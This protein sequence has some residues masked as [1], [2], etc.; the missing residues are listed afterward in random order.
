MRLIIRLFVGLDFISLVLMGMQ[1]WNIIHHFDQIVKQPEMVT[2][3]LKF[4]MFLLV[5]I[6]GIGLLLFKKFGFIL[7]YIQFP[8]RFYLWVFSLGFITFFP[9]AL[10][11]YED[12]W[13]DILLKFCMATEFVRL[14]LTIKIQV[15]W[16]SQQLHELR[17][18]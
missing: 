11:S 4:P 14:Y 18:E 5:L 15:K 3:V 13:F 7:Y 9:E 10:G 2:A 8:F 1:L 6:G 17:L 16:K 12:Y